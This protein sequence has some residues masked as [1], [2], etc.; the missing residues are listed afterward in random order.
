MSSS[1]VVPRRDIIFVAVT[2][3]LCVGTIILLILRVYTYFYIVRKRGGNALLWAFV[4]WIIAFPCMMIYDY[5][6][7]A[8]D[9]PSRNSYRFAAFS[10][11]LLS[12]AFARVGI[13]MY[14]FQLQSQVYNSLIKRSLLAIV[15]LNVSISDRRLQ[16]RI[17]WIYSANKTL[18]LTAITYIV[19]SLIFVACVEEEGLEQ[20]IT[21]PT[22]ASLV[23]IFVAAGAWSAITDLILLLYPGYLI[24]NLQLR[25]K[26]KVVISILMGL[27]ILATIFAVGKI[28]DYGTS[29]GG[30]RDPHLGN[31][32]H[33]VEVWVLLIASS[34]AP[35]WP[36]VRQLD[37]LKDSKDSDDSE[38]EPMG[39]E[40]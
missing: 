27:G 13:L 5:G 1:E 7:F 9:D 31:I 14:I 15:L 38:K 30:K 23:W 19:L 28:I 35:L 34:A 21:C 8:L 12:V 4:A 18:F 32:F 33:M 26:H 37:N 25:R 20:I 40:S 11:T 36:L 17:L 6:T 24:W 22:N 29:H 10:V 2:N 16:L 3:T 39:G